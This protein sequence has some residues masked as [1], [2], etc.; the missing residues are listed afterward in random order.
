VYKDGKPATSFDFRKGDRITA[1]IMKEGPP[2]VLEE[3]RIV[4][5]AQPAPAPAK[6]L[7]AAAPPVAPP[8]AEPKKTLPKTASRWPLVGVAGLVLV[9]LGAAATVARRLAA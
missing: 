1:L 5:A 3:K 9:G 8:P 2:I 6:A 7:P 4:A